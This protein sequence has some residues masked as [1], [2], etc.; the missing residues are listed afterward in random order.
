[1]SS[2]DTLGYQIAIIGM[3]GR[4][5]GAKDVNEFCSNLRD[6]VQSVTFFSDEELLAAGVDPAI[7]ND[8]N[9]IKAKPVLEDADLFDAAFFGFT[10]R[11]AELMDP[12]H[13]LFLEC[14]WEALEE[15][16]YDSQRYA[17]RIGLYAGTSMNSYL[18][19]NHLFNRNV[20]RS[21]GAFQ[22]MMM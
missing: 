11:E 3:A 21:V 19:F 17:G 8:P 22:T 18:L 14:A 1:M 10:P 12:Q 6:G 2:S 9:Y 16:G 15:A 20:A 7:L 5:P 13:R 4:F